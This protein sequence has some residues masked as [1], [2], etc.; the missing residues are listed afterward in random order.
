MVAAT[1]SASRLK[2]MIDANVA[3]LVYMP[4]DI[5]ARRCA[6]LLAVMQAEA[7]SLETSSKESAG[8]QKKQTETDPKYQGFMDWL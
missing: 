7:R 3:Q 2:Q 4:G 1:E 5:S 8:N 6:A